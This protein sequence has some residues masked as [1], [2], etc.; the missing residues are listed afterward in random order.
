MIYF[1]NAQ[2]TKPTKELVEYI[3][4]DLS[5]FYGSTCSVHEV[6]QKTKVKIEQARKDI[7]KLI[8]VISSNIFFTSG[9]T[10]ANN[11]AIFGAVSKNNIKTVICS[12]IEHLS[13]LNPL[14]VLEEQQIIKIIYLKL[15]SFHNINIKDLETILLE[16]KNSLLSI[17]H[18]NHLT[19]N[20]LPIKKIGKLCK[21]NNVI[22]HCDMAQ[23]M[24]HLNLDFSKFNVDIATAT[25][26]K[27]HGFS[28]AGFIYLSNNIEINSTILGEQQ[29]YGVR[30]G[31]EN[32][33]GIIT[34]AK[35]LKLAYKEINNNQKKIRELSNYLEIKLSENFSN[36][37][38]NSD[39]REGKLHKIL[40]VKF[41]S[42][43]D[44][45]ILIMKLDINGIAVSKGDIKKLDINKSVRFSFSKFNT[46]KEVDYCIDYLLKF[47]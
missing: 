34:M 22:F 33:F 15:D 44:I 21:Q 17:S 13:I 6:S 32:L 14:K 40:N 10:E 25:A 45:N 23:T 16:N 11:L 27:F 19:G 9:A 36:I 8:N 30:A 26:H 35:A 4:T 24:G 28:G 3:K 12:P 5:N 43:K 29:E 20:I 47:I 46:K 42:I 18:S 1:D 37:V 2:T 41:P 31:S 7:A 38:Y 39:I